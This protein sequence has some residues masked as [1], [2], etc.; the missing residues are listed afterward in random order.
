MG[1]WETASGYLTKKKEIL[2]K[3]AAKTETQCRFIHKR[4]MTGLK[5]VL[6][7]RDALIEEIIAINRELARDQTWRS[8]Q[9]LRL[10]IQDIINREQAIMD[11]SRQVLQDAIAEKARIAGELKNS[12][13]HRQV[14]NQYIN[15][16]TAVARGS[17][18]NERG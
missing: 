10:I 8:M 4:E 13:V 12:R 2:E 15:P 9:G 5:R 3:I 7:E 18:I 11:R 1:Q 17:R 6:R 14:K 16:W